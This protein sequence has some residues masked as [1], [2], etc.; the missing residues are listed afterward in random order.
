M[1]GS[2]RRRSNDSW[3]LT[4]DLGRD[5]DGKRQ[6]K[7]V[8]VKGKK[9]EAE[10]RM[11]ELLTAGDRG[12]PVLTDKMTLAQWLDKWFNEYVV[13]GKRQMTGERYKRVIERYLKP[14]L[15]HT[16][17]N[18]LSPADI[19]ALVTKWESEGV[20]PYSIDYF[21]G[22][23][24]SALKYAVKMEVLFRNPA[25]IV[26]TP[27]VEKKEVQPPDINTVNKILARL[28]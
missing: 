9:A 7:Y 21:H 20:T 6:R 2:I 3:E 27:R 19:R 22:I 15:G 18:R 24:S 12:L 14:Y 5:E 17:L 28:C 1:K 26:D 8:N 25:Q 4:I 16:Q 23:L 13:S 11:R 10:W